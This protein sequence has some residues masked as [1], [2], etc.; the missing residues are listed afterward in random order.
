[1]YFNKKNDDATGNTVLIRFME[2]NDNENLKK[3]LYSGPVWSHISDELPLHHRLPVNENVIGLSE[4]GLKRN[5]DCVLLFVC[6]CLSVCLF[7]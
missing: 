5:L 6:F 1:M 4:T 2:K 3:D 7:V